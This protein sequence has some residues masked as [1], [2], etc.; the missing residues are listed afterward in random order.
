[1]LYDAPNFAKVQ[2]ID[3]LIARVA[4]WGRSG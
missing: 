3:G 1:V 4:A 2:E